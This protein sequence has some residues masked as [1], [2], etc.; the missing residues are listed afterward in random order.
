MDQM[1]LG[2]KLGPSVAK[3]VLFMQNYATTFIRLFF[4]VVGRGCWTNEKLTP[5]STLA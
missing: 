2:G 4:M 1:I 5:T 3:S